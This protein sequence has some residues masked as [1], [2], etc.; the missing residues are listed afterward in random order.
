MAKG[1]RNVQIIRVE[2]IKELLLHSKFGYTIAELHEQL[3][4]RGFSDGERTI[5][6]DIGGLEV[7][8]FPLTV[9]GDK[10]SG[11]RYRL[12]STTSMKHILPVTQSALM[13]VYLLR[14]LASSLED[15]PFQKDVEEFF[16]TIELKLGT[17]GHEF[18]KELE[19]SIKFSQ[20]VQLSTRIN[21][22]VLTTLQAA[23]V[24]RQILEVIY[25]SVAS[26]VKTRKLGPHALYF[27]HGSLYLLAEDLASNKVKTYAVARFSEVKMLSD[28]PYTAEAIDP[29]Q[30]FDKTF[31]VF[32]GN[33]PHTIALEIDRALAPF[34]SETIWHSSQATEP[35]AN[36]NTMLRF[37]LSLTPDFITWVMGYG[38][39]V[40]VHEPKELQEKICEMAAAVQK[41]YEKK[42]VI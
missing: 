20:Q 19:D 5:R 36:G 26:G 34:L 23:C 38:S 3:L 35:M 22:D 27:D 28:E 4:Q 21:R 16:A 41:V 14:G 17:K 8:G 33:E 9:S 10:N 2:K 40:F 42:R 31:G 29:K 32:E 7:I 37:H 11:L 24:E 15:S 30:F 12:E 13:G 25:E 18:L 39:K 1:E 6:R